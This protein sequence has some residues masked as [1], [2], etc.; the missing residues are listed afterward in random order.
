MRLANVIVATL[1]ACAAL[2]QVPAVKETINVH[3]VDAYWNRR[4]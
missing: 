2:A 1:V 3:V 4:L